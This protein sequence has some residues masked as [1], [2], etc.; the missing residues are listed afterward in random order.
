MRNFF[1]GLTMMCLGLLLLV[2]CDHVASLP[3]TQPQPEAVETRPNVHPPAFKVFR[4]PRKDDD[5]VSLVVPVSAT[6]QQII[7]LL[8]LAKDQVQA[9]NLSALGIHARKS[10]TSGMME[11]FRG[12]RCAAEDDFD[13]PMPCGPGN[14]S[15]A[16]YQWGINHDP[17][18]DFAG[19]TMKDGSFTKLFGSA[20]FTPPRTN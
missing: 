10:L 11:V 1:T 15:A 6:D 13:A 5:I 8:W 17:H 7:S 4:Q 18:K 3:S 2:G 12:D 16:F 9:K 20:D 14:H 19:L